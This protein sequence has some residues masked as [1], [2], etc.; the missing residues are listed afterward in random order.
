[1]WERLTV[2]ISLLL[3]VSAGAGAQAHTAPESATGQAATSASRATAST[4]TTPARADMTAGGR[5]INAVEPLLPTS[6][7]RKERHFLGLPV[8]WVIVGAVAVVTV[9][10]VAVIEHN[11][12][13]WGPCH[14]A[15]PRPCP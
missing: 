12:T 3:A 9:I 1:M 5:Q 7:R 4:P 6:S 2:L 10:T 11:R 13:R 15:Q 14:S 8:K